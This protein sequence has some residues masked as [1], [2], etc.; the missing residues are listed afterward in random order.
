MALQLTN[1]TR[2][3]PL[4]WEPPYST[5]VAK[6]QKN[7]NTKIQI[8]ILGVKQAYIKKQKRAC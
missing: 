1:L 2:I 7:K 6:K 3:Q 8:R 5:G 4:A